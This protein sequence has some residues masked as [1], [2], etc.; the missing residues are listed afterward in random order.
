MGRVAQASLADVGF[1]THAPLRAPRPL[2][3]TSGLHYRRHVRTCG[4]D[5]VRRG[6]ELSIKLPVV[7]PRVD[8]NQ[9]DVQVGEAFGFESR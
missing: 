3:G 1:L 2:I 6:R 8:R 7:E 4:V 5:T 9:I